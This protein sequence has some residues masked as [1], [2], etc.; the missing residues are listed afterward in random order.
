M[1]HNYHQTYFAAHFVNAYKYWYISYTVP[2]KHRTT[3]KHFYKSMF[4]KYIYLL[5]TGIKHKPGTAEVLPSL[6][7]KTWWQSW[8]GRD[9]IPAT[10]KYIN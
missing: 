2:Y 7:I 3:Q 1:F 8:T 9:Y 4:S 10:Q 6:T 5:I